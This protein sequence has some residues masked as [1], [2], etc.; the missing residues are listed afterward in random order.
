MQIKARP[1]EPVTRV[2]PVCSASVVFQPFGEQPRN[3]RY[4]KPVEFSIGQHHIEKPMLNFGMFGI[5]VC[6]CLSCVIFICSFLVVQQHLA[7]SMFAYA[8][9]L[10]LTACLSF[11]ALS[12]AEGTS[13]RFCSANMVLLCFSTSIP[14]HLDLQSHSHS[15]KDVPWIKELLCHIFWIH[16]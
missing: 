16:T 2:V 13:R 10:A 7:M 1:E 8:G 5:V 4:P 6:W 11:V 9:H 12:G 14:K 3:Y 15:P